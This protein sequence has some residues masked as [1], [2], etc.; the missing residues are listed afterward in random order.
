[1]ITL[2][3]LLKQ[4]ELPRSSELTIAEGTSP[5]AVDHGSYGSNR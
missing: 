2:E 3:A 4:K 1:M 5:R